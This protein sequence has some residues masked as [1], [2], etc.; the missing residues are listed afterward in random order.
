[1]GAHTQHYTV[2]AVTDPEDEKK[3]Q[4]EF[5]AGV[6][7]KCRHVGYVRTASLKHGTLDDER[8]GLC[9]PC[10]EKEPPVETEEASEETGKESKEEKEQKMWEESEKKA[11]KGHS[12]G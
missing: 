7:R 4:V 11:K 8:L 2:L 10:F 6:C 9:N 1:M 12:H 3:K 5:E